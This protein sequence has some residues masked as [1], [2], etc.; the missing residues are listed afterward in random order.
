MMAGMRVVRAATLTV[1]LVLIGVS[2]ASAAT[3][4]VANQ[5]YQWFWWTAPILGGVVVV[6]IIALWGGYIAK[7]LFPKY[8]GRKVKD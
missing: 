2:P 3:P 6:M 8:R 4:V 1:A 5:D 7:V